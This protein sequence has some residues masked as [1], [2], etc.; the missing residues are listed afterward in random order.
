MP[1]HSELGMKEGE[2]ERDL[3]AREKPDIRP[4]FISNHEN[5]PVELRRKVR[6]LRSF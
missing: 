3:E 1:D 5:Q 2:K 4:G 6:Q